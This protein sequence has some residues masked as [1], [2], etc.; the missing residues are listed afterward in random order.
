MARAC[1]EAAKGAGASTHDGGTYVCIEGPQF[2]TRAESLVYR[3]WGVSVIGMTAMP[4]AKLARE[5]EL[6]YATIALVT[7]YDCWHESE[8]SVSVA[9]VLAVLAA[10]AE[11]AQRIIAGLARELP[12]VSHS[13]A[14]NALEFAVIT[15]PESISEEARAR[16]SFLLERHR[17]KI[18]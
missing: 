16:L 15:Q 17:E 11:L 8:E 4:E 10:N 5:A 1:V 18:A 7:D 9:A 12:D 13:P 14:A 3:G 6:P 2:S